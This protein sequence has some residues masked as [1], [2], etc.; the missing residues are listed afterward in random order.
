MT[1]RDQTNTRGKKDKPLPRGFEEMC[2]SLAKKHRTANPS[3]QHAP[4]IVPIA[5]APMLNPRCIAV[6]VD[7]ARL[8]GFLNAVGQ[9]SRGR[10]LPDVQFWVQKRTGKATEN[11][12][13]IRGV[14]IDID[15]KLDDPLGTLREAG[16]PT[17]TVWWRTKNGCKAGTR[18]GW[19]FG[20]IHF[21]S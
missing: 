19:F 14:V 1:P 8:A 20:L 18:S 12:I 5:L 15:D 13:E 2:R 6:E 9:E 4:P 10:K 11:E 17:P 21:A 3:R 7:V 16:L